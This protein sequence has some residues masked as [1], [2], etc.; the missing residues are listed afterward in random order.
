MKNG[1]I[2]SKVKSNFG[3][4]ESISLANDDVEKLLIIIEALKVSHDAL[5]T[6]IRNALTNLAIINMPVRGNPANVATDKEL[7]DIMAES[8]RQALS[9]EESTN[10]PEKDTEK[11]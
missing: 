3:G 5:V 6:T 4:Y 11:S 10:E 1:E 7:M 8:F 9:E 2:L